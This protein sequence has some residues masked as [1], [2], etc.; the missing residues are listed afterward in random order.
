M[1]SR[2][3]ISV[4]ILLTQW[5][6]VSGGWHFSKILGLPFGGVLHADDAVLRADTQIHRA[7]HA[8]H[9][10]AG[11]DPVGEVALSVD[12]ERAEEA[13]VDMA[14]ADQA[15][16]GGGVDE[17]AAVGHGGGGAAGVDDVVGIEFSS[18]SLGA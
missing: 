13:R 9:L 18:P 3:H 17:A 11:D 4:M 12:L 6:A 1:T 10:L 14:A 8:G 2:T 5:E 16:V 7:A 15:E